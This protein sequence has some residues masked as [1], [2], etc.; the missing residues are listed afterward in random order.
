[1]PTKVLEGAKRGDNGFTYPPENLHLLTIGE[2]ASRDLPPAGMTTDEI[3]ADQSILDALLIPR[4]SRSIAR[5]GQTDPC[6]VRDGGG[7]R[8]VVVDGRRRFLA[9][10]YV[11]RD[12]ASFKDR[13]GKALKAPL[14]LRF[15]FAIGVDDEE[16]LELSLVANLE[17]L[18]LDPIDRANSAMKAVRHYGWTQER[19]ATVMSCDPSTVSVLISIARLPKRTKALIKSGKLPLSDARRLTAM[20]ETEVKKLTK[21]IED[22]VAVKEV[23]AKVKSSKREKGDIIS[24]TRAELI[25]ELASLSELGS[26]RAGILMKWLAGDNVSISAIMG[27]G[28]LDY[29]ILDEEIPSTVLIGGK[30]VEVH[31]EV[32]S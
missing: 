32:S 21:E 11:N 23:M 16:A 27:D 14:P 29:E 6:S 17:R 20:P 8:G 10:L 19:V 3:L 12:F 4:L 18:D 26:H 22:G 7:G 5:N 15:V 28:E 31:E 13:D 30:A 25:S 1:M 2:D 9:V 24:R